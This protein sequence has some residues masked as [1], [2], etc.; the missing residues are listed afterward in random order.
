RGGFT[1]M[2][3]GSTSNALLHSVDC[4]IIVVRGE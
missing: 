3:L 1:G 4:P 2:L